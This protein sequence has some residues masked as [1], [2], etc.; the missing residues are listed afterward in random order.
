MSGE[1][2]ND[3]VLNGEADVSFRMALWRKYKIVFYGLQCVCV[4]DFI[5]ALTGGHK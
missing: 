1:R 5:F 2:S 4:V 3:Y